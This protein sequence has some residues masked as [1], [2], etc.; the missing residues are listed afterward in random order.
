MSEADTV[1]KVILCGYHWTGCKALMDLI[2]QGYEVFVYTHRMENSCPDLVGLCKKMNIPY[3]LEKISVENMPFFPDMIC[4]IYYR[5]LIDENVIQKCN[6]K[7]FNLHPALLPKYR[8]CSSLTWAMI[9]GESQC[10]YTYHYIDVSC[11]TGAIILQETIDIEPFDTQLTLYQRVMFRSMERFLEVC[12]MVLRGEKGRPQVG[13]ATYYRR[14]C[15]FEGKINPLWDDETIERF[16]RA[17]IYPPYKAAEYEN[18][19]IYTMEEYK[20]LRD[21]KNIHG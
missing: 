10:G 16:I 12:D 9:N 8:G 15:P 21:I 14:G 3:S 11:D 1:K 17:M 13:T 5:Y 18:H 6:G 19:F 7:I 20:K 4:S 2:D